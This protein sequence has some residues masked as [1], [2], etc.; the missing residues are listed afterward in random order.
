MSVRGIAVA[1]A[2]SLLASTAGAGVYRW[3][4][5]AGNVHYGD[6]PPPGAEAVEEAEAPAAPAGSRGGGSAAERR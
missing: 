5:D 4:D 2:L 3:V 6:R 1:A